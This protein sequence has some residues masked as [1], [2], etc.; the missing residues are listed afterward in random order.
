ME[1]AK[2]AEETCELKVVLKFLKFFFLAAVSFSKQPPTCLFFPRTSK[3]KKE[4][5]ITH[6]RSEPFEQKRENL[7]KSKK[8][9]IS[10]RHLL[11]PNLL[12][13]SLPSVLLV[14]VSSALAT[15]DPSCLSSFFEKQEKEN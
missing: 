4:K 11:N 12:K 10:P 15:S 8:P 6:A 7:E 14:L 2:K 1:K 9:L 3:N 5:F 13:T